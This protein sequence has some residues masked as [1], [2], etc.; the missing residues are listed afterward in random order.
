MLAAVDVPNYPDG[1]AVTLES[2]FGNSVNYDD[3]GRVVS[4]SIFMQVSVIGVQG[5]T[6]ETSN[7]GKF[8][9]TLI[10]W[11]DGSAESCYFRIYDGIWSKHL[12][13]RK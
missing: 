5:K 11:T 10:T 6:N 12:L 8:L 1:Q 4:A 13:R 2:I 3:A 7:I 9:N